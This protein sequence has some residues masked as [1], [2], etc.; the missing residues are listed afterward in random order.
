MEASPK[1]EDCCIFRLQE[2]EFA[3]FG[4]AGR[5]RS[6]FIKDG[7]LACHDEDDL[8]TTIVLVGG[9]EIMLP[10]HT[11]LH[12]DAEDRVWYVYAPAAVE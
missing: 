5:N 7:Q 9:A 2:N 8:R 11:L 1:Y 12:F 3:Y 4:T 10:K 6:F